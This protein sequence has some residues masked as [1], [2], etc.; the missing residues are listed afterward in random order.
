[1]SDVAAEKRCNKQAW[2]VEE[3]AGVLPTFARL[4]DAL[5]LYGGAQYLPDKWRQARD[6]HK[7][8][9]T[10]PRDFLIAAWD[11]LFSRGLRGEA[12]MLL[13]PGSMPAAPG[14]GAAAGA[15]GSSRGRGGARAA[16]VGAASQP[17]SPA[18]NA[19]TLPTASAG[20]GSCRRERKVRERKGDEQRRSTGD[21][22][23]LAPSS[24]QGR[25]RAR[26]DHE[27]GAAAAGIDA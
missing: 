1:M 27:E 11:K 14:G 3:F 7:I 9:Q 21:V 8:I 2:R 12:G 10:T 19:A 13:R 16:L 4:R 23:S 15:G 5:Q 24:P 6:T 22:V 20:G 25:K 17:S 26:E 18:R